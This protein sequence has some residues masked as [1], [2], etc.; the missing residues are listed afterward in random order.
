[1]KTIALTAAATACLC[2]G[3]TGTSALSDR[4]ATPAQAV[5]PA[6]PHLSYSADGNVSPLFCKIDNPAA[7]SVYEKLAP[8]LFRL[9]ANASPQQVSA[10]LAA[11]KTT[12]NPEK[13]AA[14]ALAAWWH[15]WNFGANPASPYYC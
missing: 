10:A 9:G 7:L 13:C 14:Y 12:T 15:H 11:S 2:F 1:M 5:V 3:I 8:T 4:V 6:C